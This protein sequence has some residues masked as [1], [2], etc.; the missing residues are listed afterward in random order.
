[1]KKTLARLLTLA[2]VFSMVLP[3][4][5]FSFETVETVVGEPLAEESAEPAAALAAE[6]IPGKNLF[7]G[8]TALLTFDDENEANVFTAKNYLT[9]SI[10]EDPASLADETKKID[11]D[12]KYGKMLQFH[13]NANPGGHWTG[14]TLNQSFDGTR[15]YWLTWDEYWDMKDLSTLWAVFIGFNNGN[16]QDLAQH[17]ANNKWRH[18][19]GVYTP[20]CSKVDM[21]SKSSNVQV[22]N[23]QSNPTEPL[24]WY[25]DNYGF[26]PFY[27]ITYVLPDGNKTEQ[28]L[29]AEGAERIPENILTEYTPKADYLPAAFTEA[30]VTYEAIGWATE[31]NAVA[32]LD[33][34]ALDGADVTLYP[35]YNK[36]AF[37]SSD[38]FAIAAEEDTGNPAPT[39]TTITA[40]EEVTWTYDVGDTDALVETTDTTA[41]VTAGGKNGAVKLTATPVS[42]ASVSYD[43]E[44]AVLGAKSWKPGLNLLTGTEKALDFEN[45]A[46]SVYKRVFNEGGEV[47]ANE[48]KNSTNTS[49]TVIKI[50]GGYALCFT[51]RYDPIEND[52]PIYIAYDYY[53]SFASHWVMAN[54]SASGDYVFKAMSGIGFTS[55]NEWKHASGYF[56]APDA[57]KKVCPQITRFGLE[58]GSTNT[59]LYADN[60]KF[61]PAYKITYM[62]FDNTTVAQT[63]YVLVD[64]NGELLTEYTPDNSAVAGAYGYSLEPDGAKA[65]KIPLANEDIVLYPM[66]DAPVSFT[67]GTTVKNVKPDYT[68]PYTLPSPQE[69]GLTIDN[70]ACWL[71]DDKVEMHPGDVIAVKDMELVKGKILTAYCQDLSLPAVGFSYE[72]DRN[73]DG[74]GKYKYQEAIQDEGRSVLHLRQFASTYESGGTRMTDTRSHYRMKEGFDASEYNIFQMSYKITSAVNVAG[75]IKLEDVTPDKLSEK[76]SAGA[77][78][79]TYYG[80]STFYGGKNGLMYVGNTGVLPMT[81]DKKY[82]VLEVDQGLEKNNGKPWTSGD[83]GKLY[84]FAIDAVLANY[85]SDVYIDYVRVYRDGIFTVTYDTNAPEGY[86]DFESVDVA[87]DTGRGGGT[88]YLLKGEHPAIEDL[89]FRGWAL[90]PDATPEETVEAIDLTR[91]TTVYAVWSEAPSY[92]NVDKDNVSIRSGSDKVNGIRFASSIFASDRSMMEEYGFIIA[93]EDIL[94][95]NE[96]TFAFKA[97]DANKPLYVYGAAYDKAKG[98]DYQYD[99]EGNK[100]IFTA[101]CTNIPAEH[102]AT[103][104]VARTYAKY[105]VSGNTFTVYGSSVTKSVK[106]IAQSIKDAGGAAYEDNKDYIDSIL[107]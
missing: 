105:A 68:A 87:P 30:G 26:Y 80:P 39:S 53:G 24:N 104:L 4:G 15:N 23:D 92:P 94:G 11:P 42:D 7:T 37:L 107:G 83:D 41:T 91:S 33:T 56:T 82:H 47:I 90:T 13:R 58:V 95:T 25:L 2:M 17:L 93:R 71:N 46:S 32:A 61:I 50:A 66:K 89:I 74:T 28:V 18:F 16:H 63:E 65:V 40:L 62:N 22:V 86:E 38:N 51:R 84:G 49:N 29:F 64:E 76:T 103:K 78:I 1:M 79:F 35:V 12:G 88:G 67:D 60:I 20:Q 100:I 81:Y 8:T 27:K 59:S 106:E 97:E 69:L 3:V 31:M 70:F 85:S 57:C 10:V 99:I 44:V 96:L 75:G 54:N 72:G 43:V 19:S 45:A 102:Y 55:T 14:Y 98:I 5:A 101:V 52:R 34:V 73:S 6:V 36:V 77:T 21:Q 9:K 48:K